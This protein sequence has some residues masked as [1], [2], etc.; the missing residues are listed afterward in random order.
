MSPALESGFLTS[1]PPG[2]SLAVLTVLRTCMGDRGVEYSALTLS[3]TRFLGEKKIFH[4]E[5]IE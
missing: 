5:N 2:K 3:Q 4:T 1:G